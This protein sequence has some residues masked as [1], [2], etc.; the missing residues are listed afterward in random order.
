MCSHFLSD[1]VK[2]EK[3][4]AILFYNMLPDGN[5][6]DRSLHAAAPVLKGEKVRETKL[7]VN[8]ISYTRVASFLTQTSFRSGSPIYGF[9]I[10]SWTIEWRSTT[11]VRDWCPVTAFRYCTPS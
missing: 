1:Q 11:N 9:G 7:T 3:G 8:R 6:D 4:K 2:P 5:Y 10:L